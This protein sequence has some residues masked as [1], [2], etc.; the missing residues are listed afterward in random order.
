M[1]SLKNIYVYGLC[2]LSLLGLV[3]CANQPKTYDAISSNVTYSVPRSI[4]DIWQSRG[5]G[6]DNIGYIL[7]DL[8]TGQTLSSANGDEGFIPASTAKLFTAYAALKILGPDYRF[9]T[10]L[11]ADRDTLYLLG[12]GDPA[13]KVE[14][15]MDMAS[16]LDAKSASYNN[17]Y[18]DDS[19]Y[20]QIDYVEKTQPFDAYYNPPVRALS[21]Q[22]ALLLINWQPSDKDGEVLLFQS[23]SLTPKSADVP[24]EWLFD[25]QV[26]HK[27]QSR[28]PLKNPALHTAN[29]FQLFAKQNGVEL[30]K[31]QHNKKGRPTCDQPQVIHESPPIKTLV[32]ELL[33]TS[34][35][36]Q[37]ELLGL[38][39]AQ[40]LGASSQSLKQSA[41]VLAKWYE[42][43]FSNIDW[44]EFY[45]AN[46]SGL[47]VETRI[48]PNH[49]VALLNQAKPEL[50]TL[51]PISGWKGWLKKRLL[52]PDVS[53]RVWAKT[54]TV[55]YGIGLSGYLF[56]K[57]ERPMAF[58][59]FINDLNKRRAY[60]LADEAGRLQMDVAASAWNSNARQVVDELVRY[61]VYNN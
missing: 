58:T 15:L 38:A 22:D 17:F 42:A 21:T 12:G 23:P 19:L 59:I 1:F 48:S 16:Q 9:Q 41:S 28:F 2:A 39:V 3:G 54:G 35:N 43:E 24:R 20:P 37:A 55:N 5:L 26:G 53:L 10:K 36:L 49:M 47:S 46:H 34:S 60:D 51:M 14:N 33:K 61:W 56:A 31:A 7:Q 52:T 8:K 30:P 40:S 6:F 13:L 44:R 4:E 18:Y 45:L 11:C 29:L 57:S 25:K 27:G 32:N 50:L